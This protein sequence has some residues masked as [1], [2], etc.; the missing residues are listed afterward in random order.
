MPFKKPADV[1]DRDVEWANLSHFA[2]DPARELRLGIVW[3]RRRQ[4]KS[5]LLQALAEATGGFYYEAFAGTSSELLADLGSKLAM[6]LGIGAP[7]RLSSWDDAIDALIALQSAE[8]RTASVGPLVVLDEFPFLAAASPALPSLIARALSPRGSRRGS[9]RVRLILCGSALRFMV[10]LLGGSAPLRGRAGLEQTIGAFD[11][12]LAREYWKLRDPRLAMLAYAVVG[13]T[14]AYKRE[15]LRDDVPRSLR[16]FDAWVCRT[17]LNP[18]S[19]LFREGRVLVEEEPQLTDM[20][21]YHSVLAAIASGEHKPSSIAGRIGRPLSALPHVLSVLAG[22]GLIERHVDMFRSNRTTYEITE[23][24]VAFHH[25]VMRPNLGTFE[26]GRTEAA[27]K[28]ARATFFSKLVGPTFERTCREWTR[29]FASAETRR[30]DGMHV[31]RGTVSD[32]AA[33]TSHEVDVVALDGKRVCV[34]GEA[35]WSE[36]VSAAAVLRLERIRALLSAHGWDVAGC[37]LLYF[38][39]STA[40][41]RRAATTGLEVVDATRLYEGD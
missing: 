2:S 21:L 9:S 32:P 13:G 10:G 25:A 19:S 41:P 6:H 4:G 15:F 8:S 30:G 29:H 36:P 5:F 17:A 39:G 26:R 35:K 40:P 27:W 3:G 20:A 28:S 1:F 11:F 18:A 38:T 34:L 24:I 31:G 7:L 16:D 22:A 14:P 23:P 33:K 37:R 12:R